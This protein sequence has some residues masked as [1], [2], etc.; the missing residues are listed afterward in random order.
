[1]AK[2]ELMNVADFKLVTLTGDLAAAVAEEMEGL[3]ALSF[4]RVKIPAGGGTAFELPGETEDDTESAT[5]IV[6]VILD[7]NPVNAYWANKFAGGNE[8]PDCSSNDGRQGIV[9]ATGEIRNCEKCPYN[10]FGSDGEGKACKNVHRLFILREDNPVPVILSLPPTS[11]RAMRDY[12]GKKVLLKG[13]RCWQVLTRITLKKDKNKAGILYS[14]A[15]FSFVGEL[16]PEQQKQTEAMREMVRATSKTM[17]VV[18]DDYQTPAAGTT[19]NAAPQMD[20]SG[21]MNVPD[22]L[23]DELPFA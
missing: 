3:G 16:T 20:S 19:E 7:H 22:D 6:G 15:V 21:F 14:K 12:I 11:L 2:N 17:D 8:H 9:R 18:E 5:E 10:Q 13:L 1:M 23:D 4:D